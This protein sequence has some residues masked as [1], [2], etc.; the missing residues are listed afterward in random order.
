MQKDVTLPTNSDLNQRRI[1]AIPRGVSVSHPMFV[2]NA[3]NAEITD[4]EGQKYIDFGGGMAVLNT[5]QLHPKVKAAVVAQLELFSHTFFQITPYESYVRLAERLNKLVPV[6][7]PC[8]T[9]LVTT[10]AEANENAIKIARAYTGR[11]GVIAFS[12]AFHG[13]TLMCMGLTGRSS[14][15]L[16]FGPMPPEIFHLPFP[17]GYYGCDVAHSL[18][19]LDDLFRSDIEPARVAAIIIEPV[20]GEGG[21][22]PAPTELLRSLRNICDQHGILLIADE[23][24]SGFARTGKLFAMEHSGVKV[25]L[26]TMAKSLAGGFPLAAISGKAEI[27]DAPGPGGLGGTYAGSPIGCAAANA[28]LDVIEEEKLC[29][30]SEKIGAAM[31]ARLERMR[32]NNAL[33]SVIGEVRRLGSMLAVELVEDGDPT[34]PDAELTKAVVA[35]AAKYGLIVIAC[36]VRANVVRFLV[37]LTASDELIA[38]GMEILERSLCEIVCERERRLA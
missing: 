8:K 19:A 31:A 14:Y 34:K 22:H 13:R 7:P 37:P 16:G 11:S 2:A 20:Q 33:G 21:F 25:D 28:V 12:G 10:G 17:N 15:K 18:A 36:G 4:V 26:V 38:S 6:Q 30:R 1:D 5:G 27:M 32:K 9:L 29:E 35:R 24:Q 3:R 23:V